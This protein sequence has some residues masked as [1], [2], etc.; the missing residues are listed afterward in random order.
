MYNRV[1]A[2]ASHFDEVRRGLE[3][4]VD[5]YNKSVG[6]L[7]SRVLPAARKFKELGAAP[8]AEIDE[9]KPVQTAARS[10]QSSDL[11]PLLDI[12]EAEPLEPAALPADVGFTHR[13]DDGGRW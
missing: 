11:T 9:L 8:G 10:L 6:S 5:A 4:A 2:M 3:K 12:V 13:G 7:E 1:L